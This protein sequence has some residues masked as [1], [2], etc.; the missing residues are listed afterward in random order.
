M[1][2]LQVERDGAPGSSEPCCVFCLALLISSQCPLVILN[3][4]IELGS[5][6]GFGMPTWEAADGGGGFGSV[7]GS[8]L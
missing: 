2:S 5:P 3:Q 8:V 1:S 4:W 7:L 6:R